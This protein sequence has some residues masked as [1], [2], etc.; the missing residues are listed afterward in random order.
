MIEPDENLENEQHLNLSIEQQLIKELKNA[1]SNYI[2]AANFL[3]FII[4]GI[5]GFLVGYGM[6]Q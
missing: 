4:G 5:L 1:Q 6:K 3:F 2:A